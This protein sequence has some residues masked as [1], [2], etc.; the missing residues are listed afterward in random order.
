MT[1]WPLCLLSRRS[2]DFLALSEYFHRHGRPSVQFLRRRVVTD[3]LNLKLRATTVV[4]RRRSELWPQLFLSMF[5]GVDFCLGSGR[6]PRPP[7][8]P[9]NALGPR[10]AQPGLGPLLRALQ[11]SYDASQHRGTRARPRCS[12]PGCACLNLGGDLGSNS[13]YCWAEGR[14]TEVWG[15]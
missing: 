11:P 15:S 10:G 8:G 5:A 12:R 6:D 7:A 9:A 2:R 14:L 4:Q 3:S 1:L 13:S